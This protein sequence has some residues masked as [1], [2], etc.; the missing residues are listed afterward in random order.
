M[1]DGAGRRTCPGC[2]SPRVMSAK[3]VGAVFDVAGWPDEVRA[4]IDGEATLVCTY[5]FAVKE[6]DGWRFTVRP[7]KRA[8]DLARTGSK[9]VDE[10]HARLTRGRK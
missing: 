6:P 10:Y 7:V 2:N 4:A 1:K 5:C 9:N 8:M 3:Y